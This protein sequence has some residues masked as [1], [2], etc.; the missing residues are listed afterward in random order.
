MTNRVL[1]TALTIGLLPLWLLGVYAGVLLSIPGGLLFVSLIRDS[2][3]QWVQPQGGEQVIDIRV[4]STDR[5]C[6]CSVLALTKAGQIYLFTP[7]GHNETAM[8]MTTVADLQHSALPAAFLLVSYSPPAIEVQDSLQS[9]PPVDSQKLAHLPEGRVVASGRC[10]YS[11]ESWGETLD[12]AVVEESGLWV[13]WQSSDDA[14]IL[15]PE[16]PWSI[17]SIVCGSVVLMTVAV[18]FLYVRIW[19]DERKNAR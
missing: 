3:S 4:S 10:E 6:R 8:R 19:R 16:L 9:I 18:I 13:I 15:S 12:A 1:R 7:P 11:F 14:L 2:T 5:L 17:G